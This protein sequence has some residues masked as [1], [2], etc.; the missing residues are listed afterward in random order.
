M[1]TDAELCENAAYALSFEVASQL[2]RVAVEKRWLTLTGQVADEADKAA[3]EKAVF[4]IRGIKGIRN[5]I[6]VTPPPK[7]AETA[8]FIEAVPA[9]Q[10]SQAGRQ[11][12]RNGDAAC[13]EALE[14]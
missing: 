6:T 10:D 13:R 11:E 9:P 3:A 8:R 14:I 7:P 5:Y 1:D 12:G 2:V 4:H